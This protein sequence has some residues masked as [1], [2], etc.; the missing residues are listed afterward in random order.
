MIIII[1]FTFIILY[2]PESTS[3]EVSKETKLHKEKRK[4]KKK[5]LRFK[6]HTHTIDLLGIWC[7]RVAMGTMLDSHGATP[8]QNLVK[9]YPFYH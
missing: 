8:H 3:L 9:S 5:H 4:K 7:S 6:N 2:I 1:K